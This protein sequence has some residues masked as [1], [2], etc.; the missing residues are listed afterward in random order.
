VRKFLNGWQLSGITRFTTGLPVSL[1]TTGDL[2]LCGCTYG[3]VTGAEEPNYDA[4]GIHVVKPRESA[5]HT[6]FVESRDASG[7]PVSPFFP[8][9]GRDPNNPVYGVYGN[10][11]RRFFHGP[12]LNNWDLALHKTTSISEKVTMEFRAE[13]FN[14]LNHAQFNNP[15]GILTSSTF[16]QVTSAA[17][18]RIGQVALKLHF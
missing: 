4:S 17:N 8:E 15:N 16:G 10:A 7:N 2:D 9:T 14:A 11:N 18:P 12:G 5:N 3:F 6:Y 13:F 1:G